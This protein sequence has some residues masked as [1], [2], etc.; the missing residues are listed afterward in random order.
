MSL[1]LRF[2]IFDTVAWQVAMSS[3]NLAMALNTVHLLTWYISQTR[4]FNNK[5]LW[6]ADGSQPFVWSTG[7]Q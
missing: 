1:Y 5:D 4:P 3:A 7:D 6:P 2:V